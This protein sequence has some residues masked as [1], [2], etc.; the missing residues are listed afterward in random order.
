MC[1]RVRRAQIIGHT[2]KRDFVVGQIQNT[3]PKQS[4]RRKEASPCALT[5]AH[6]KPISLSCATDRHTAK[7]APRGPTFTAGQRRHILPCA[8]VRHTANRPLLPCATSRH[9]ANIAPR[10]P[11][12]TAGRR[13]H[14]LPCA[15]VRHT[16]NRPL[17]RVPHGGTRQ[18]LKFA[19][20]HYLGTR[21]N[22]Q[23]A[24]NLLTIELVA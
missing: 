16:A 17:C 11:T 23:N 10:G 6:G 5:S 22:K 1:L 13:R 14:I 19:V 9:T 4:T 21:Q 18:T 12:I 20:C 8:S 7:I 15:P 24:T 3:R 2:A